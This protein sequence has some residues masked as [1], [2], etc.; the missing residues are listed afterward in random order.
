MCESGG[1]GRVN[2]EQSPMD[3]A[4]EA[5]DSCNCAPSIAEQ[6][7]LWSKSALTRRNALGLGA[8]G[9]VALSAFG[10][11][12]GV[13][14]AYA[15]SYEVQT[16]TEQLTATIEPVLIVGIGVRIGGMVISLYLPIFSLY[17]ELGQSG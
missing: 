11:G 9:A 15:A 10:V 2:V 8:I 17:G 12:A 5:G 13:S 7:T 4:L 6:R 3:A 16:A 14:A 1:R